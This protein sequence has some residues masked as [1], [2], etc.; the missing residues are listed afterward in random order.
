LLLFI[1]VIVV[2]MNIDINI[3]SV[4]FGKEWAYINNIFTPFLIM[5]MVQ[6]SVV[7]VSEI[8]TVL[9]KQKIR[10]YWDIL[11]I[12]SLI[13]LFLVII[14]LNIEFKDFI[15]FYCTLMIILYLILH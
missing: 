13:S 9:N 4:L 7:P 2:Y 5:M 8:L 6:F 1:I 12:V 11:K 10:L 3:F 15:L 14:F